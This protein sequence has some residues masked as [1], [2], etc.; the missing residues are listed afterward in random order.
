MGIFS[1]PVHSFAFVD[2]GAATALDGLAT[3]QGTFFGFG[4]PG[5]IED[6][7]IYYRP[8]A[9]HNICSISLA[10]RASTVN[11]TDAVRVEL[12]IGTTTYG[13]DHSYNQGTLI[14]RADADIQVRNTSFTGAPVTFTFTPCAIVV[15]ASEYFF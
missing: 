5:S 8:G 7:G 9:S 2:T 14:Q 3:D 13:G 12:R 10:I 6:W 4:Q 15:G 1:F 11:V